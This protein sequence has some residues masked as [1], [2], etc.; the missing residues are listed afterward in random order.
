MTLYGHMSSIDVQVGDMVTRGKVIGKTGATGLALGDHLHF[1]VLIH[2]LSVRP[3]EW[4]DGKWINN[5]IA[6]VIGDS[7]N[8]K[9]K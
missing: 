1:S 9:L 6:S 5:R 3:L 7:L 8:Y 4:W 2:G